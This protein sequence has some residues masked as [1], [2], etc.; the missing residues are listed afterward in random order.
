MRGGNGA[1]RNGPIR[2]LRE[3]CKEGTDYPWVEER[4]DAR[5]RRGLAVF[6]MR[7]KFQP[8]WKQKL[9]TYLVIDNLL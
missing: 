7:S 6:K 9:G 3:P 1:P 5:L 4:S 8:G 2:H